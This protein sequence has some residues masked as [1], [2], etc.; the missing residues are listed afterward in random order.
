MKTTSHVGQVHTMNVFILG[1]GKRLLTIYRAYIEG[2]LSHSEVTIP[3]L[4]IYSAKNV[5]NVSNVAEALFI[6]AK[7]QNSLKSEKQWTG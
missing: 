5:I 4:E 1:Q 3:L 2:Y 6:P 7:D